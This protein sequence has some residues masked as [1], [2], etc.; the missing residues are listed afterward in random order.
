MKSTTKF[1]TVVGPGQVGALGRCPS[2]PAP[3]PGLATPHFILLLEKR[4]FSFV[5]FAME[6][7]NSGSGGHEESRDVEKAGD[8]SLWGFFL[9]ENV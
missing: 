7:C 5:K 3:R 1:C 4:D 2:C 9:A 6:S 8:S